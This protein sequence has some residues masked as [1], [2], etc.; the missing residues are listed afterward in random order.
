VAARADPDWLLFV[1]ERRIAVD[2]GCRG[3]VGVPVLA[4][5]GRITWW[6]N[7][8]GSVAS[9]GVTRGEGTIVAWAR[10][11]HDDVQPDAVIDAGITEAFVEQVRFDVPI[12]PPPV[13]R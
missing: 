9:T 4:V 3:G 1:D 13:P 7:R 6:D 11:D 10:F 2:S 5:E 12:D 8:S